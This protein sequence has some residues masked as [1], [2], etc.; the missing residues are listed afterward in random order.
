MAESN[1]EDVT[2]STLHEDLRSGFSDLGEQVQTGFAD[3]KQEVR[4]GFI[5]LKA[6]LVTGFRSL[7]TRESSEEMIRLLRARI[8]ILE[9]R[10]PH[11]D[12]L[13]ARVQ[14]QSLELRRILRLLAKQAQRP[15]GPG[16]A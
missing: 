7:P 12:A 3:L 1:P 13:D 11:L 6:T 10:P 15:Y 2:L 16:D 14:E 4:T 8:R 9:H 5:D